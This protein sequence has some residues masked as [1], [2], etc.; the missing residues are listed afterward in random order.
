LEQRTG[1]LAGRFLDAK[2][3]RVALNQTELQESQMD[4]Q[5]MNSDV[6]LFHVED[7]AQILS[8]GRTKTYELIAQGKLH[9]IHLGRV[10]RISSREIDRFVRSVDRP[11]RQPTRRGQTEPSD[12]APTLFDPFPP[13]AA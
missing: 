12:H 10:T 7:A 3:I 9:A 11:E 13:E 1:I 2:A 5:T 6:R 8:I 4:D